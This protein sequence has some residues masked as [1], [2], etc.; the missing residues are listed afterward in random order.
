MRLPEWAVYCPNTTGVNALVF[1]LGDL[2]VWFSY[3]TPVAFS[4]LGGPPWVRQNEWGPTTG[5][6]L[7]AI[8][9]GSPAAKRQRLGGGAFEEALE[10]HLDGE[11]ASHD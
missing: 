2:R 1:D 3:K 8:D 6:H 10:L 9:G 4:F 11:E 5:K 7:N